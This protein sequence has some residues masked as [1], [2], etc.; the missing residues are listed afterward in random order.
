MKNLYIILLLNI[1]SISV[2]AK[3]TFQRIDNFIIK[4]NLTSNGKV[5]IIVVDSADVA[6]D[7][8]NGTFK[9]TINGFEQ[10]LAFHNGVAV[11]SHPIESSTFVYFKHKN[12]EKTTGKLYFLYKKDNKISP[13]KI[14]GL[15]LLIIPAII[16]LIAYAAKRLLTTFIILALVY[17][18]FSYSKGLSIS[19][20]LESA[21]QV[22]KNL[23]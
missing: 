13:I 2:Q 18:Y 14:N 23:I 16:L 12:Q 1:C 6:Q 5:A 19:Q 8:I 22:I 7:N 4:E 3:S 15:L 21:F 20:L 11:P 9:F 17:G 10:T